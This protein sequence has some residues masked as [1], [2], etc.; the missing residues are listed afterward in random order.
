MYARLCVPF[1]NYKKITGLDLI[2]IQGSCTYGCYSDLNTFYSYKIFMNMEYADFTFT[3]IVWKEFEMTSAYFSG[4]LKIL[5]VY[6][7]YDM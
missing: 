3:H 6:F 1:P 2:R 7:E 4:E 5:I